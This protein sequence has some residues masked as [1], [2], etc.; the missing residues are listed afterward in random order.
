MAFNGATKGQT[1]TESTRRSAPLGNLHLAPRPRRNDARNDERPRNE[2]GRSHRFVEAGIEFKDIARPECPGYKGANEGQMPPGVHERIAK[3]AARLNIF[4]AVSAGRQQLGAKPSTNTPRTNKK[5]EHLQQGKRE[6]ERET[7]GEPRIRRKEWRPTIGNPKEPLAR[8]QEPKQKPVTVKPVKPGTVTPVP[9][10]TN[11]PNST[12]RISSAAATSATS[13]STALS[14]SGPI[15]PSDFFSPPYTQFRSLS[16]PT[17]TTPA[18]FVAAHPPPGIQIPGRRQVKATTKVLLK[19]TQIVPS[20]KS[21]RNTVI[22]TRL[23]GNFEPSRPV[24]WGVD[25]K[26]FRAF[27]LVRE[28]PDLSSGTWPY[29]RDLGGVKMLG[30]IEIISMPTA[31]T[32]GACLV[33]HFENKRYL[34]GNIAE[35]TQRLVQTRKLSLIRLAHIFVTGTT[36]WRTVGGLVGMI[37]TLADMHGTSQLNKAKATGTKTDGTKTDGTKTEIT[38]LGVH[39]GPH[40]LHTL[41]TARKFALRTTYP[42]IPYEFRQNTRSHESDS[43]NPDF[44]DEYI[45]VW[46][47]RLSCIKS[48]DPSQPSASRDKGHISKKLR[49]TPPSDSAGSESEGEYNP[50]HQLDLDQLS[51]ETD[52]ANQMLREDIVHSMFG[53]RNHSPQFREMMLHDV[54]RNLPRITSVLRPNAQGELEPYELKRGEIQEN[55]KVFVRQTPRTGFNELPP[56][57]RG[58]ASMCYIVK[59]HT[60]RGRF[61]PVAARALGVK[62]EQFGQLT[63]GQSVK[64]EDGTVVTPDMVMGEPTAG[65]GFAVLEVRLP[66][67]IPEFLKRPEWSNT[68]IMKDIKAMYWLVTDR[69]GRDPRILEFMQRYSSVKHIVLCAGQVSRQPN[70]VAFS[71]PAK[72]IVK[73]HRI[74]PERFPIPIYTNSPAEGLA[75]S[76][77]SI[78]AELGK[79]GSRLQLAPTAEFKDEAVIPRFNPLEPLKELE[80]ETDLMKMV[81]EAQA[82][83]AEPD[84]IARVEASE[85]DM[86][87]RDTEIVA[88]GTG[89]ALPSKYRNVSANLIRVPG[90]GNYILDCGENTLGQLRRLYGYAGAQQIARDLRVIY[91]SHGHADHHLGTVS[92]IRLWARM[93]KITS[94]VLTIVANRSYLHFLREYLQVEGLSMDH[95]RLRAIPLEDQWT[96]IKFPDGHETGLAALNTCIVNHGADPRAVMLTWPSGLK[97]AYSGD[98]RPSAHFARMAMGAH[99]LIHECTFADDKKVE[100]IKKQHSTMGE[101]LS[102]ARQMQARRVLLTHFSQRYAKLPDISQQ[103]KEQWSTAATLEDDGDSTGDAGQKEENRDNKTNNNNKIQLRDNE[104]VVLYAFDLMAIKLGDF[105]YAREFLPALVELYA[106]EEAKSERETAE[107]KAKFEAE[108]KRKEAEKANNRKQVQQRAVEKR[109]QKGEQG[110]SSKRN[111]ARPSKE[112]QQVAPKEGPAKE[113]EP[114]IEVRYTG[115]TLEGIVQAVGQGQPSN[116]ADAVVADGEGDCSGLAMDVDEKE[117]ETKEDE[118]PTAVQEMVVEKT[119]VEEEQQKVAVSASAPSNE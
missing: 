60:T 40:L 111:K 116:D 26:G 19:K 91:I 68:D 103:V 88:L 28:R 31:D 93:N 42:V 9:I 7:A 36:S 39:G 34:F 64:T 81:G 98:C 18:P 24:V 15:L 46:K 96:D 76:F 51:P 102:V 108:H 59:T 27:S 17:T 35:G 16:R 84:F 53:P 56:I 77:K 97:I 99:L 12:I 23:L 95:F 5:A 50:V 63:R 74:D 57:Q 94:K 70:P 104:P 85:E 72:L 8:N 109:K 86:P 20:E 4:W 43:M 44:E 49:R 11:K 22:I 101:A 90:V 14:D 33:L 92:V 41:A 73:M 119:V 48:S 71:D 75:P 30:F 65:K 105:Q 1:A 47:F 38:S 45:R 118:R 55:I 29:N 67:L 69:V 58:I 66:E 32:P 61:D 82:R 83:V 115:L 114:A 100:A 79:T 37:L 113:Q 3:A 21:S 78:E 54:L 10:P 80:Q 52:G 106:I 25:D 87:S 6:S 2:A 13:A 89:S 117:V 107:N 110:S 112:E 62:P